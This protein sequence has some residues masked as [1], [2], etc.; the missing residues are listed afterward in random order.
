M[1]RSLASNIQGNKAI[2]PSAFD[3]RALSRFTGSH[4]CICIAKERE[5]V[6]SCIIFSGLVDMHIGTLGGG[7]ERIKGRNSRGGYAWL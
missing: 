4:V 5:R 7:G 1:P 3:A 2:N 6:E